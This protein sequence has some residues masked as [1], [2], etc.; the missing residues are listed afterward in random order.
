MSTDTGAAL[1]AAIRAAPDDDAPWL[2]YAD[3]LQEAGRDSEARAIRS[4]LP[5]LREPVRAGHEVARVI[6]VAA[7]L[8]P[9][10]RAWEA[11]FATLPAPAAEFPARLPSFPDPVSRWVER[12]AYR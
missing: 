7:I 3:W 12:P 5:A 2:V 1:A 6:A 11:M 8:Q 10:G 9:C 4:H